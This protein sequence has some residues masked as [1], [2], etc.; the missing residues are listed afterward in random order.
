[1]YQ[2]KK[3]YG[4]EEG[5]SCAF[6]QWRAK[7]THCR[8]IHGYPLAFELVFESETLDERNWVISFG[9]L[10]ELKQWLK[11]SFDH[12]TC[13]A[14]DDPDMDMFEDLHADRIIQLNVVPDV[15]CEK[16]AEMVH[17]QA[18]KLLET[19]MCKN[20]VR[21]VSVT[22]SEHGG[23][24]A[25]YI[26]PAKKPLAETYIQVE[27]TPPWPT[28]NSTGDYPLDWDYRPKTSFLTED[29]YFR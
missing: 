21:L 3:R 18:C 12:K 28:R 24:S 22:C 2:I 15:G 19:K 4:H 9:E 29:G 7:D 11:D 20:N 14:L 27:K 6:R 8:F 25:T 13:V 17:E 10:K 5:L 23:N 26:A 16:F 1:M